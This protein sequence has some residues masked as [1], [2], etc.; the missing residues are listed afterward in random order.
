MVFV[1]FFL[2]RNLRV[3]TE[4]FLWIKLPFQTISNENL[5]YFALAGSLL[6]ILVFAIH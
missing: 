3:V 1:S 5:F 6:F 2:A 4:S